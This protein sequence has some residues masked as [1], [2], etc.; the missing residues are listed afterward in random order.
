T[1]SRPVAVSDRPFK[2]G[3]G[4][5]TGQPNLGDYIGATAQSGFLYAGYAVTNPVGFTDGQPSTSMTVPDVAF[6]RIPATPQKASL[7]L[8]AVTFTESGGNGAIDP[9]DTVN[10]TMPLT[11]YVTNT[12]SAGA[13]TGV[14]ATLTTTTPGITVANF[15]STY[16]AIAAGA[17]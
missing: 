8:G 5:D 9:G 16:P 2:A 6:K 7:R 10:L 1:W 17:T 13:I 15:S 11:N 14:Q 4:N 12:L 3:W